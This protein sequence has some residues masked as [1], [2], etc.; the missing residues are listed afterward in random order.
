MKRCFFAL[1][2]LI[3]TTIILIS[4]SACG[5]KKPHEHSFG[6]WSLTESPTCTTDGEKIQ[7]CSCGES[8]TEPVPATGHTALARVFGS[9]PTC[10]TDGL[11]DGTVCLCGES[12][13][14]QTVIPATGHTHLSQKCEDCDHTVTV[15][16]GLQFVSNGDGTCYVSGV[17]D[18]TSAYII[19]PDT[20]NGMTV[21]GIGEN[22]FSGCNFLISVI[23]PDSITTLGNG[24]FSGCTSLKTAVLSSV[25]GIG[26]NC[27][28]GCTALVKIVIPEGVEAIGSEAF[29]G[30]ISLKSIFLPSSV[31]SVLESAF[32]GTLELQILTSHQ[33]IPE[34]WRFVLIPVKVSHTHSFGEWITTREPTCELAG[35]K[36]QFCDCGG[37]NTAEIEKLP[38][39]EETV[40][41]KAPT[42][43]ETGL[44]DGK[45][46]TICGTTTLAQETIQTE[47]HTE[48]TVTGKAPTCTETGLTDGKRC[49]VCG[50]TTLAQEAIPTEPHTEETVTGK[51]PTCTETGLT[52]GKRCTVCGTTTLEQAVIPTSAHDYVDGVC[53]VCKVRKA[54][55]GLRILKNSDGV[56]YYVAGLGSCTD[57]VIV[58]PATYDGGAITRI[59]DDAFANNTKITGLV[60]TG[61]ITEIGRKAFRN[62][63]A[64]EFA[65]LSDGIIKIGDEAFSGCSKLASV[66]IPNGTTTIGYQVFANCK[67]TDV[68]IPPSVVS[69]SYSIFGSKS[70]SG[71]VYCGAP[72]RPSGWQSDWYSGSNVV[73]DAVKV[74]IEDGV[75]YTISSNNTAAA[76]AYVGAGGAVVIPETVDGATVITIYDKAFKNIKTI[77]SV[78]L[79][80]TIQKIGT[81]AFYYSSVTSIN[82]PK[83]L[84]FI[85]NSAFYL[86]TS[87]GGEIIL[88]DTLVTLGSQVFQGCTSITSAVVPGSVGKVSDYTFKS[89]TALK[90]VIM[91]DGMYSIGSWAFST[92]SSLE[93]VY[94]PSGVSSISEYAFEKCTSLTDI[95]IPA[96]LNSF[97]R[98]VFS[99]S[100]SLTIRCEAQSA[101]SWTG[102]WNNSSSSG[103]AKLPTLWGQEREP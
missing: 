17:G 88:P 86:C 28:S 51:A 85:G 20:Y 46:C 54:S 69:L 98:L 89:C 29:S 10:T 97:G 3:A 100:S 1:F 26:N 16:V 56:T 72:S 22:A 57:T 4:L 75:K 48:E 93:Y 63:T 60:L 13:V 19:I 67:L 84:T 91:G 7:I 90:T 40:T 30:C 81:E 94:I 8:R 14:A 41:G 92:C 70:P 43:T 37:K 2:A 36:V 55:E 45:R 24:A 44:T 25:G 62:C 80:S 65:E 71:T 74:I 83:G 12:I 95:F 50:T 103:S 35:I 11:T 102:N 5:T 47:P 21:T 42:C 79:P 27:F 101:G 82:F 76:V 61:N 23:L 39:T 77:T 66:N 52:D 53:S 78:L 33:A 32:N 15:S 18:C 99:G 9:A 73:W 64:L 68:V 49:T 6:E 38:H 87:L 59:A 31:L 34:G 58:I 96:T